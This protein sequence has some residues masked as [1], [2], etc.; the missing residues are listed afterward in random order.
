ML[1]AIYFIFS[2]R[3]CEEAAAMAAQAGIQ[4]ISQQEQNAI[5]RIV[6]ARLE[7]FSSDDLSALG[8]EGFVQQLM[9]VL[10][11]IMQEW[12]PPS[13]RSLSTPLLLVC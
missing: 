4:L 11:H 12:C 7:D 10:R 13:K 5:M 1:P 3:Q 8:I 6:D 2:R 9:S